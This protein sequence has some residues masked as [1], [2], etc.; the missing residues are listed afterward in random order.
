VPA[1]TGRTSDCSAAGRPGPAV[2]TTGAENL[3]GTNVDRDERDDSKQLLCS[4]CRNP[5]AIEGGQG[6]RHAA[7]IE[8]GI[9]LCDV[10]APAGNLQ[11][12]GR[13]R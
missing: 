9:T 2:N 12:S 3:D 11:S 13:S 4:A 7:L 1:D 10:C 6:L 8:D 5:V